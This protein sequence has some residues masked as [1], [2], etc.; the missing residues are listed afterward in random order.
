M[1]F[2]DFTIRVLYIM[3][4]YTLRNIIAKKNLQNG[5]ID[6]QHST[7][8]IYGDA[9]K[10]PEVQRAMCVVF[11]STLLHDDYYYYYYREVKERNYRTF[12]H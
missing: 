1:H 7:C 11:F 8:R 6:S 12:T 4:L 3:F 10:L 5:N 2:Y 9:F